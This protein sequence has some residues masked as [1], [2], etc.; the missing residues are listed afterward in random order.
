MGLH[1]STQTQGLSPQSTRDDATL[2]GY[3]HQTTSC[4]HCV[5]LSCGPQRLFLRH[6][7]PQRNPRA[8]NAEQPGRWGLTT[9]GSFIKQGN[10]R[11][12]PADSGPEQLCLT[13]GPRDSPAL[14]RAAHSTVSTG[15][16][17]RT[18]SA[19]KLGAGRYSKEQEPH[20]EGKGAFVG[21]LQLH[22]Q[23][24]FHQ[25]QSA[26]AASQEVLIS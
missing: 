9:L 8:R 1:V 26:L 24:K 20:R 17:R 4:L 22:P 23:L 25:S 11:A 10:P 13:L 5:S 7:Q 6:Q 12:M 3:S 14:L 16:D 18:G 21:D 19:G 2:Q 15:G